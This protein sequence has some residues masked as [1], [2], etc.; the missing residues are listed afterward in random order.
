MAIKT[1]ETFS[2][3]DL[4]E[5]CPQCGK[6]LPRATQLWSVVDDGESY[7][8]AACAAAA[9]GYAEL[10]DGIDGLDATDE[11]KEALHG[12]LDEEGFG[13]RE[14]DA[15]N[16][17]ACARIA[18]ERLEWYRHS[19][20]AHE[21]VYVY[22]TCTAHGA[23]VWRAST[24]SD[25]RFADL[26]DRS[27]HNPPPYRVIGPYRVGPDGYAS[28][29][30]AVDNDP[31]TVNLDDAT[32]WAAGGAVDWVDAYLAGV[33]DPMEAQCDTCC[34]RLARFCEHNDSTTCNDCALNPPADLERDQEAEWVAGQECEYG[35]DGD[36]A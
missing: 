28:A 17:T 23:P 13:G 35:C 16:P 22:L 36:Q 29:E 3:A 15:T 11:E 34:R 25:P 12:I 21:A 5:A 24:A 30:E 10:H 4:D 33:D 7:C 31:G 18:A 27:V 6:A 1:N 14:E 2:D 8:S 26:P 9:D 19:D 32:T 20:R